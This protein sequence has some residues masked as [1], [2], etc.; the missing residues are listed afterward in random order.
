MSLLSFHFQRIQWS[1]LLEIIFTGGCTVVLYV[2]QERGHILECNHR[3]HD[4]KSALYTWLPLLSTLIS[5]VHVVASTTYPGMIHH[6]FHH[7]RTKLHRACIMAEVAITACPT[8]SLFPIR[9]L[10]ICM[11]SA[12]TDISMYRLSVH[13]RQTMWRTAKHFAFSYFYSAPL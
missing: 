10:Q 11:H 9:Y 8:T 2:G 6:T 13:A 4:L 5:I 3:L 1:N 12:F 7:V